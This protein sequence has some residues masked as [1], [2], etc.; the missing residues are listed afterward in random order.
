MIVLYS[1]FGCT[2]CYITFY[3]GFITFFLSFWILTVQ[4]SQFASL[5]DL[6]IQSFF[7]PQKLYL[8]DLWL[9][10]YYKINILDQ[11]I[12]DMDTVWNT[13]RNP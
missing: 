8:V 1:L 10:P 7:E 6:K 12:Y 4:Q 9:S 5:K 13:P 3:L 2:V 11:I